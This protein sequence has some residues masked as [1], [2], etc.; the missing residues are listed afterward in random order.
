MKLRANF[1]CPSELN[2]LCCYQQLHA[3]SLKVK[4]KSY[5][6][7]VGCKANNKIKIRTHP[8]NNPRRLGLVGVV[9]DAGDD[10][11][12]FFACRL[13]LS[14]LNLKIPDILDLL[15]SHEL[16]NRSNIFTLCNSF[17]YRFP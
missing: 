17:H 16:I 2:I 4:L 5:C 9:S 12:G 10:N 6:A 13:F 14:V 3:L 11:D 7:I 1:W 15:H 8:I